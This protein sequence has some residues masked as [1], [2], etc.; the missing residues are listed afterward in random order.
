MWNEMV[1]H[2]GGLGWGWFGLGMVHMLLFWAV[3]I[4]GTVWL[5]GAL[6]GSRHRRRSDPSLARRILDARFAR[7]EIDRREFEEKAA[8]LAGRG[9]R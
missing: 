2:M 3:V 9:R 6:S 5:V 7:G 1:S 4:G 8:H